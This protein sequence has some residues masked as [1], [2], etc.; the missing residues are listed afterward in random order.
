MKLKSS[1]NYLDV[2]VIS[3]KNWPLWCLNILEITENESNFQGG[4]GNVNI[5]QEL[6][7]ILFFALQIVFFQAGLKKKNFSKLPTTL[8]YLHLTI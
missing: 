5:K 6:S 1:G 8:P 4:A 2:D 3:N 7:I